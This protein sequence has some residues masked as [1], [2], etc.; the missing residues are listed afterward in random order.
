[1]WTPF[2]I[3]TPITYFYFRRMTKMNRKKGHELSVKVISEELSQKFHRF[4]QA[5]T[6]TVLGSR[7]HES[8]SFF[9]RNLLKTT[10]QVQISV[11]KIRLLRRS[12]CCV[13]ILVPTSDVR[14]SWRSPPP[15]RRAEER[16][17]VCARRP[18]DG[19][20]LAYQQP[21]RESAFPIT[22]SV[23][24]G[25]RKHSVCTICEPQKNVDSR[26]SA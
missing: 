24:C 16:T 6:T 21:Y 26:S 14:W 18:S 1:M 9:P 10:V 8:S 25:E 19:Q 2:L 5:K 22:S 12:A 23:V 13:S 15:P 3:F 4:F 11:S 17:A 7:C 20:R